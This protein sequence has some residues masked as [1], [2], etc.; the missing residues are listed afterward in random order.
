MP[1]EVEIKD[2]I[3]VIPL[4]KYFKKVTQGSHFYYY[5]D[6]QLPSFYRH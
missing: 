3:S 4:E 6:V 1:I 5:D 2:D